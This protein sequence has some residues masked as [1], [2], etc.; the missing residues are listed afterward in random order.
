VQSALKSAIKE[1]ERSTI[2][3]AD[4][5]T[6]DVCAGLQYNDA[7]DDIAKSIRAIS[8]QSIID[9]MSK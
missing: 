6:C 5:A 3:A 1:C 7:C 4:A 2:N 9:G 8:Q